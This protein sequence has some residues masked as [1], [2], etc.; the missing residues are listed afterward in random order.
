MGRGWD[1]HLWPNAKAPDNKALNDAFPEVPV[2]LVR[3]DGHAGLANAKA[4]ELAGINE[5]SEIPGGKIERIGAKPSGILVDNA[6]EPIQAILPK[7]NE[8]LLQ[9]L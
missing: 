3:V 4:L 2:W 1:Q 7:P 6:M 8:E 9:R 5:D